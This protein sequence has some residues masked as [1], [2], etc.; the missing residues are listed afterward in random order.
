MKNFRN[1][2]IHSFIHISIHS[3]V[4]TYIHTSYHLTSYRI[5]REFQTI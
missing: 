1:E 2:N 5:P 4:R 3:Y